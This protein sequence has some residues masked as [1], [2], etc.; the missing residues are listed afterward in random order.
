[1]QKWCLER[2]LQ[3]IRLSTWIAGAVL[4]LLL[5]PLLAQSTNT[6]TLTHGG[7]TYS[8]TGILPASRALTG[9]WSANFLIG[10]T[11]HLFQ[12]GWWYRV[13]GMTREFAV[14][15][16]TSFVQVAANR[17]VVTFREPEGVIYQ[18]DYILTGTGTGGL[19][20]I[21]GTIINPT[22]VP[23]TVDTFH[24][25]DFDVNVSAGGDTL[26][27]LAPTWHRQTDPSPSLSTAE[28]VASP[29]GLIAW[30]IGAFATVRALLTDTDIDNL[31]NAGSPFGPGD[32]TG[33]FQWRHA[34]APGQAVEISVQKGVNMPQAGGGLTTGFDRFW[35]Q[36]HIWCFPGF[37]NIQCGPWVPVFGGLLWCRRC[38]WQ[39][40]SV[41]IFAWW[42]YDNRFFR[43][44]SIR[45]SICLRPAVRL[46]A[47]ITFVWFQWRWFVPPPPPP[48][49]WDP[50]RPP[51][52]PMPAFFDGFEQP[53]TTIAVL[54]DLEEMLALPGTDTFPRF[55]M[56]MGQGAQQAAELT[57]RMVADLQQEV[58]PTE[59]L[60]GQML[61]AMRQWRPSFFDVFVDFQDGSPNNPAPWVRM[62][63]S[64][65]Q[66]AQVAQQLPSPRYQRSVSP[67]LRMAS[68]SAFRMASLIG[69]DGGGGGGGQHEAEILLT[70]DQFRQQLGNV[71]RSSMR[72]LLGK[73]ELEGSPGDDDG[74][75]VMLH[76][77]ATKA[78]GT[79]QTFAFNPPLDHDGKY[80]IPLESLAA[81]TDPPYNWDE[82]NNDVVSVEVRAEVE[83]YQPG[84]ADTQIFRTDAFIDLILAED[85]TLQQECQ[86]E[87]DVNG[88]GSVD[89]QDLLVV[90]FNFGGSGE[91]D[92][93]GD[94]VVDDAD[95]LIVLFN[96]GSTC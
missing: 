2:S 74:T 82:E 36:V 13:D 85:M 79:S 22:T 41:D 39:A 11:D 53:R 64:L 63:E 73:I 78:D 89:D 7:A 17:V 75:I 81:Q 9:A 87:G 45:P 77:R 24:Y 40:R 96:F 30:Q 34:L 95:L 6:F 10:T 58:D 48:P 62:G 29:N 4:W 8:V 46:K 84:T 88:D 90:L 50:S 71:G 14:S 27:S 21:R 67:Q 20:R 69:G 5:I 91:G 26:V 44:L 33:A 72:H 55:V 1:M 86:L 65:Q 3:K 93:N 70:W 19:L 23:H 37:V 25:H 57:G 12:N 52:I 28:V 51:D 42:A 31:N 66:M 49:P 15:T 35:K 76:I 47:P 54:S 18:F 60:G 56:G 68:E 43:W 59:P 61:E 92:L 32:G 16:Q 94:G 80:A 38:V 83:G